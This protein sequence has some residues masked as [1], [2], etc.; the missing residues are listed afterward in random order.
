[1]E[2]FEIS[3]LLSQI[4][5]LAWFYSAL[6]LLLEAQERIE[7]F[8][9]LGDQDD[10]LIKPTASQIETGDKFSV[11]SRILIQVYFCTQ[12]YFRICS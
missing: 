1:M 6:K 8:P 5:K 3:T 4:G 2:R 7:D 12:L 11:G 9:F 10:I